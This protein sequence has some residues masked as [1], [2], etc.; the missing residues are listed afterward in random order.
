MMAYTFVDDPMPASKYS[1]KC[2]YA[3]TPEFIVVHNTANDASAKNEVAY[4]NTN[5]ESGS[6]S[7]HYAIDDKEVRQSLPLTR[8]GYHAGD[9]S[10]GPGNRKG[11][12]I[13]ICYSK[14]GGQRYLDSEENAV[15][16][17]AETLKKRG[18][19]IDKVKKHQD[20]SGK[21]CP[22]RILDNGWQKF[23]NRIDARL[24][25][26]NKPKEEEIDVGV[27]EELRKE[28]DALKKQIP[29]P[30][31]KY[32]TIEEVPDWAKESI[33]KR[34]DLFSDN[35]ALNLNDDMIR[36]WVLEDRAR[37]QNIDDIAKKASY[38]VQ[39]I[40]NRID[41]KVFSDP[42]KLDL[43]IDMVRMLVA[44]DRRQRDLGLLDQNFKPI[45][46]AVSKVVATTMAKTGLT[47]PPKI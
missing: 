34:L 21:Y 24:K 7:W 33:Q 36:A 6:T 23:V 32:N 14:S 28:I 22:H 35:K 3:M 30:V 8:N 5:P 13:E 45:A 4:I 31:K 9:G 47:N 15:Q 44:E 37:C 1:Q 11:I 46:P 40:Q 42:K 26:L 12:G 41:A 27:A 25:E 38:A 10:S 19:G 2:P 18:W 17:I 29:A 16:F 43:S 20:F 39:S